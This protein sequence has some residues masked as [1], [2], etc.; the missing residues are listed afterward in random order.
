RERVRAAEEMLPGA[1]GAD[2]VE[3]LTVL[4]EVDPLDE[5]SHHPAL[6]GVDDE[7]L[8]AHGQPA[9]EPAGSMEDEVHAGEDRRLE[10]RRRLVCGLGIGD[11]RGA[12]AAARPERDAQA[13]GEGR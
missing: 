1:I 6:V 7:L 3:R 5:Y 12:Q 11:L 2:R 9:L 8:V 4:R 13:T 10:R